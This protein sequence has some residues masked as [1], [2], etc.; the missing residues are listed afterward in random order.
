MRGVAQANLRIREAEQM[1]FSRI[2]LPASNMDVSEE[3]GKSELV[4][5]RW[6]VTRFLDG[7]SLEP[8]SG[9]GVIVL[10][11]NGYVSGS[12]GCNGFGYVDSDGPP[13]PAEGLVYTITDDVI[14]FEGAPLSTLIACSGAEYEKRMRHV[15]SGSV[16]F[17]LGAAELTLIA[18]DG[19]GVVLT[20]ETNA[21]TK[22]PVGSP[23]DA[24]LR[25]T[26]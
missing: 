14:V 5:V 13:D 21:H 25:L 8:P 20:Q 11:P 12:D 22:M 1:G 23:R 10:E 2:V 19:S 6:T 4:G 24:G 9:P 3:V 15:L 16:R 7:A 18:S 26:T 17:R